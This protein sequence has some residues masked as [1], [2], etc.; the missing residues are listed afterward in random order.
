MGINLTQA[1][2]VFL[3]EPS[4][5]PA[6][7]AQA[8]GRV[9]RLGQ[10]R[11]VEIIRLVMK[12]SIETRILK[13]LDK[14]YGN[15]GTSE[16]GNESAAEQQNFEALVGSIQVDKTKVLEDEF[17]ILFGVSDGNGSVYGDDEDTHMELVTSARI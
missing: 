9:H 13:M 5:N 6:V 8:I 16:E 17:D 14:K 7:E 11:N 15:S 2:R 1:N 3:M 4:F 10:K 12:D